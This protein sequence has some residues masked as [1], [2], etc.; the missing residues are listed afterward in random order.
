MLIFQVQR[1]VLESHIQCE[2]SHHLHLS[3]CKLN[4]TQDEVRKLQTKVRKLVERE[5]IR[6]NEIEERVQ[7]L[8]N[9]LEERMQARQNQSEERAQALENRFEERVQA[10]QNH[11]EERVNVLTDINHKLKGDLNTTRMALLFCSA[12]LIVIIA[13]LLGRLETKLEQING[14]QNKLTRKVGE[15]EKI[16]EF[17]VTDVRGQLV[18]DMN[19]VK[20]SLETKLEEQIDGVQNKL[21]RKLGEVEKILEFNVPDVRGQLM[22]DLTDKVEDL[23]KMSVSNMSVIN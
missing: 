18:N 22:K 1:E 11:L 21:K 16:L 13:V 7:A 19:E 10:L 20:K 3:C 4:G 2:T 15:V 14:L 8:E 12:V 9:Y 6:H 23:E 17:K 5:N